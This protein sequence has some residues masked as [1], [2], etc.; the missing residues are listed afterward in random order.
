MYSLII[1]FKNK[2]NK[3]NFQYTKKKLK[4]LQIGFFFS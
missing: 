1:L 4:S 3:K 2:K